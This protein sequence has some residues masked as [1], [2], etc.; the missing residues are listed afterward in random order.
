MSKVDT[1]TE[2][3]PAT[4]YELAIAADGTPGAITMLASTMMASFKQTP[5]GIE[6]VRA[7]GLRSGHHGDRLRRHLIAATW[8]MEKLSLALPDLG[9]N[10][11]TVTHRLPRA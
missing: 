4:V 8:L 7:A 9:G 10:L 5:E 3:T 1:P 2:Y 6:Y 11:P